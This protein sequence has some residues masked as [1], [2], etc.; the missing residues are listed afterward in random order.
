MTALLISCCEIPFSLA[1]DP[2]VA[3]A[4]SG[5]AI[6]LFA[7]DILLCIDILITFRTAYYD[8]NKDKYI[9]NPIQIAKNYVRFWFF[10]D[11]MTSFPFNYVIAPYSEGMRGYTNTLKVIR[12]MR[13]FRIAR[14]FRLADLTRLASTFPPGFMY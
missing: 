11:F 6:T 2:S 5:V 14:L 9:D 7:I 8:K 4:D 3:S 12:V 13:I 1:F 10:I